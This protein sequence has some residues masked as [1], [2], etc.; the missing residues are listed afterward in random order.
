MLIS[1]IIIGIIPIKIIITIIRVMEWLLI[2]MIIIAIIPIKIITN[3]RVMEWLRHVDLSEYA[4]NLRGSGVHG[5]LL[6]FEARWQ[7]YEHII[8]L[9]Q[10]LIRFTA[11]LLASLLSIPTSKSLLRRHLSIHVKALLGPDA[12]QVMQLNLKTVFPIFQT[13]K[14]CLKF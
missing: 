11:E 8:T 4:P 7:K 5:A 10:L 9:I 12:I 2:S 3:L 13:M 14:F 1:M 6:V